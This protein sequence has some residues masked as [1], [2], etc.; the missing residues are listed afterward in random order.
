[1]RLSKQRVFLERPS[2]GRERDYLDAVHRSRELHR[3]LVTAA[4]NPSE[5]R[6]Y[7]RR[8]RRE[9]QEAFFVVAAETQ[10]LAGVVNINDIV[11]ERER[12]GRLGYYAF[13]PHAGTGCMREGLLHVIRLAFLE[14]GLHRLEANVQPANL[15]S[16][17]LVAGL[18]FQREGD[19]RG[20]LKIGGRWRDHERWSLL[21]TDWRATPSLR[22]ATARVAE[23]QSGRVDGFAEH[24]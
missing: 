1:V 5:Y 6:D 17:A 15:R 14:L 8:T 10:E 4:A 13:V 11:R 21:A 2:V 9:S 18:G 3:G 12:S 16:I 20:Y 19:L 7:L 24:E 22:R 23:R